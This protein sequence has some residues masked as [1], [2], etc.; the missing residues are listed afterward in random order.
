VLQGV[1]EILRSECRSTD[2]PGRIG[3]EEFV[4]FLTETGKDHAVLAAQRIRQRV[5][6]KHFFT[7]ENQ[8]FHVT[9]SI[10]VAALAEHVRD[11]DQLLSMAD[12]RLYEA[13]EQGRDRVCF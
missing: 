6:E 8:R 3:G 12:K 7:M 4:V 11:S 2:Y 10:G 5:A 9:C 1:A 13:K